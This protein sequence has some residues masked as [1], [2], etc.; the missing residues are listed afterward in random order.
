MD[1]SDYWD[2]VFEYEIDTSWRDRQTDYYR[3]Y[4]QKF[5]AA[6]QRN[7]LSDFPLSIEI[8]ASY[9]CNLKCPACPRVVNPEERNID[10]MSEDLWQIILNEC[11]KHNLPAM[12]MDHEAESLMNPRFIRMVNETKTAGVIDIWLHTNANMLN[13]R[14]SEQLIDA[15]ITKI[16]FS[17]DAITSETY[18]ILR[19]G[20]NYERVVANILEFL[21]LKQEREASYIRTRVSFVEQT[22]NAHERQ[23]F[24]DLW[25]AVPGLNLITY[26]VCLDF[27]PYETPDCDS[28]LDIDQLTA[29]YRDY[30]PFNCSA[31]WQTPIIDIKGNVVPCGQPVRQH[32][33]DFILGNLLNG[34]TIESCWNGQKMGDLRDLHTQGEWYRN[35]MCRVC[36]NTLRSSVHQAEARGGA[37]H[38]DGT[39]TEIRLTPR[40]EVPS[41]SPIPRPTPDL[42]Y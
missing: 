19:P 1:T 9:H 31:P 8:E 3:V 40:T 26:Q 27:S 6:Q 35:P 20:G 38:M 42:D 39:V 34:D 21:R 36:V 22:V 30:A 16:N 12:M 28:S 11:A 33:K 32:N 29:K 23:G 14:R 15:G 25:N 5:E 37:T 4:R 13:S 2:S 18:D 7:Y 24:F 41:L 10:H 17:I